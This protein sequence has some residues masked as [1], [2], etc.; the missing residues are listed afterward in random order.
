MHTDSQDPHHPQERVVQKAHQG[1]ERLTNLDDQTGQ[2]ESTV[3]DRGPADVV[4]PEPE[5]QVTD[6]GRPTKGPN[7]LEKI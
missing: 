5:P 4:L 2:M 1:N 3:K 6:K 7:R